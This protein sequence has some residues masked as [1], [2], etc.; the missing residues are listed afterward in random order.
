MRKNRYTNT[1]QTIYRLGITS[2]METIT[3]KKG[4]KNSKMKLKKLKKKKQVLQ[5]GI[6]ALF[7]TAVSRSNAQPTELWGTCHET[8]SKFKSKCN[9]STT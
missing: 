2:R 4:K 5:E 3:E 7:G 8:K 6:C 9:E 1:S